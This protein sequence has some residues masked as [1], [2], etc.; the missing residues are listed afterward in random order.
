MK[1]KLLKASVITALAPVL[2]NS[3]AFANDANP[4]EVAGLEQQ[5]VRSIGQPMNETGVVN[6]ESG[7][8]LNIRVSYGT[9]HRIV[10]KIP[11]GKKVAITE[12][13][14]GWYKVSYN[15]IQGYSSAEYIS[16]GGSFQESSQ[17]E[18]AISGNG[19]VVNMSSNLNVRKI[20]STSSSVIGKLKSG[21]V[22]KLI[23]KTNSG[24][25][26]I[27][28]NGTTG[29]AHGDYINRTNEQASSGSN[30]INN[31]SN[32]VNNSSNKVGKIATVTASTLNVRSGA[33]TNHSVISKVYKGNVVK[34][35]NVASNGWNKVQLTSGISG[36]VSGDY[37][38]NYRE[39]SL[40][41]N[42]QNQAPS[43]TPSVGV[44]QKVQAV[45]NLAKSK[46]GS[47]YKWG[48][49]GPNSFDCS[50]LTYYV[51][52]N[53]A[54]VNLPRTSSSQASAGYS[55][56]R[57]NLKPGDLVFFNTNGKGI[58]HVGLYIGNNEMIHSPNEGQTV[59]I[60]KINNSYY[61]S[62]FVTA[63]RIIG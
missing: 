32:N 60:A 49:E 45:I 42:S 59:H 37:L 13:I 29:Y 1:N 7:T 27:E 56:S 17:E 55:V 38:N 21:Q 33:G 23:A 44:N 26:K 54:G 48:A 10:G 8:N 62:R 18:V 19:K 40:P 24:W 58:S 63:R 14:N 51:Y 34:I 2:V 25:Y 31:S 22:V 5:Q 35:L 15:G 4:V 9:Q 3:V 47:P 36:W 28:F 39:G 12:K 46:I 20:A 57:S 6:V 16:I 61:S 52:K 41:S 53:G 50:G 30:N 43:E 11:A